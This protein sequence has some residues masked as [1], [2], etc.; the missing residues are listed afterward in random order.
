MKALDLSGQRAVSGKIESLLLDE[1]PVIFGYFYN[2][3][4]A[5]SKNI[6]GLPPVADRP[7]LDRVSIAKT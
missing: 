6:S 5:T 4:Y 7:F 3:L 1:T 2:Y